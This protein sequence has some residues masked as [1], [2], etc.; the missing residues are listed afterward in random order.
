MNQNSVLMS[1]IVLELTDGLQK[2][3]TLNIA[4]GTAHLNDGNMGL[5]RH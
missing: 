2:R 5:I 1:H 4:D 3:L